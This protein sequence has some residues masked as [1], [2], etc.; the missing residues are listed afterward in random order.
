MSAG[1]IPTEVNALQT[2]ASWTER[3]TVQYGLK[4]GDIRAPSALAALLILLLW[5]SLIVKGLA[6]QHLCVAVEPVIRM[7]PVP[8][9]RLVHSPLFPQL[10]RLRSVLWT[11]FTLR[12]GDIIVMPP[13]VD[14]EQ[15]CHAPAVQEEISQIVET[16]HSHG[17]KMT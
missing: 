16:V 8:S 3:A 14:P 13:D 15:I 1:P 17:A 5:S 4:C 6:L 2:I 12:C 9:L 7:A 10:P 11:V